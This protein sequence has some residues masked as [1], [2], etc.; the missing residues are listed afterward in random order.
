[1]NIRLSF[2]LVAVLLIFGGTFL[3]I[4]LRPT[5]SES[6][7][8][9][10]LYRIDD[11][12]IVHIEVSNAGLTSSFDRK[13]GSLKWVIQGETEDVPVA[14]RGWSGTPLLL[15]G[16]Q[17]TRVLASEISNPATYGLD[18]P[19]SVVKVT[20]RSGLS[21][22]FHMGSITPDGKNQYAY[23]VGDPQLFTVPEIWARV[24]NQL[25]LEPPYPRLYDIGVADTLI[26]IGVDYDGFAVD[27]ESG[28][29]AEEWLISGDEDGPVAEDTWAELF[30]LINNPPVVRVL[31]SPNED[32]SV[33]G[34]DPP[35]TSAR[36]TLEGGEFSDFYLGGVTEDG[37]ERYGRRRG[38]NDIYTVPADWAKVIEELASQPHYAVTSP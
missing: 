11:S 21:Y 20:E 28:P 3:I 27:Y 2:L 32:I 19:A 10:W 18:P 4:Q 31:A 14:L 16:P 34:L 12:S 25:A 15:S 24:I 26:H 37:Q 30:P 7:D 6:L 22:E 29:G 13:P 33:Y 5:P 9:P 1:M 17:V 36:V 8:R 23:L 38:L 35:V